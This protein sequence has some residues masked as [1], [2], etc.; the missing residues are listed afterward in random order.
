MDYI[1]KFREIVQRFGADV[2]ESSP[3]ILVSYL[4]DMR[5]ETRDVSIIRT[6][7]EISRTDFLKSIKCTEAELSEYLCRISNQTGL[8]D[9]YL[10]RLI[11]DIRVSLS[12]N[13]LEQ[14]NVAAE[15]DCLLNITHHDDT[16]SV[17]TYPNGNRYEGHVVNGKPHGKGILY[18]ADGDRYE[19]DFVDGK[20]TGKG[21]FYWANGDR[22]EG[23]FVDGK[24]TGKG[25][26]YWPNGNCYEGDFV[27]GKRTG[28]G[29]YYCDFRIF[30]F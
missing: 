20:R 4:K 10:K 15:D 3:P 9:V 25:T 30:D 26:Y 16:E 22:Y 21:T 28:K 18:R 13:T 14:S 11:L 19:G 6:I 23:D 27:D 12:A 8:N 1:G 29:T 5:F 2:F 24:R 7:S 17:I